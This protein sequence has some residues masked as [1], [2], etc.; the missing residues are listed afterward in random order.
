MSIF[1]EADFGFSFLVPLLRILVQTSQILPFPRCR[2]DG[3]KR[4]KFLKQGASDFRCKNCRRV[5]S[6]S[7]ERVDHKSG[8]RVGR[9]L[10]EGWLEKWP[11]VG[12]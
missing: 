3:R 11:K 1:S 8:R 7:V 5:G 12:V 9:K 6:K 10:L 4:C 2:R